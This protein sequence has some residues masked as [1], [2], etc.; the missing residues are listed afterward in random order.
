MKQLLTTT[1][2]VRFGSTIPSGSTVYQYTGYDYGLSLDDTNAFGTPH[3]SVTFNSDG[4]VPFFTIPQEYVVEATKSVV[5]D[6]MVSNLIN[7]TQEVK[8][9]PN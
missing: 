1:P 2:I 3:I 8:H 4:S 6:H 5:I 9:E 7:R